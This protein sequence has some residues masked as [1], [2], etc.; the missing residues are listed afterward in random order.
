MRLRTLIIAAVALAMTLPAFA[1]QR[2][3]LV[4]KFTNTGCPGCNAVKDTINQIIS[5]FDDEVALIKYHVNWPSSGDEFYLYNPVEITT[6]RLWYGVNYVPTIRFDGKYIAD[7]SDFGTLNE[8]Y[9]FMRA[10]LDSLSDISSPVRLDAEHWQDADSIYMSI[11]V[12]A[13]DTIS[14]PNMNLYWALKTSWK[15]IPGQ[16]KY[17]NLFRDMIPNTDGEAITLSM[18]DSLHFDWSVP[19]DSVLND[20]RFI[21]VVFLQRPGTKKIIQ[22]WEGVMP[23]PT[24]VAAGEAAPLK[25]VLGQNAPN[26][27]NPTTTI[28]Y[29]LDERGPVRLSV[30]G[31]TG[32]LVTDLVNEV[33]GEGPHAATWN[34]RDRA[35]RDVA[36]GVYYYRL[37]AGETSLTKKMVLIR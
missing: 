16:G 10:T 15:R 23:D 36:S 30:Y 14:S 3:V 13:T 31:P 21:N 8:F 11:D 5:E 17:Y 2:T 19:K 33:M 32:R 12:V 22:A 24:D 4:E 26:P 37:N 28:R 1:E 29:S 34:G 25:I 18:G 7:P 9:A 6:R 20:K 35:G 27:F